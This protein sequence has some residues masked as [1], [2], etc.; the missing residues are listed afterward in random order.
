MPAAAAAKQ[1]GLVGCRVWPGRLFRGCMASQ[2]SNLQLAAASVQVRAQGCEH[3]VGARRV[4]LKQ[5]G[6][7]EWGRV[8]TG[9]EETQQATT[10]WFWLGMICALDT[11]PCDHVVV[12]Q[13][14][15]RDGAGQHTG[16]EGG[17]VEQRAGGNPGRAAGDQGSP[18]AS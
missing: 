15:W 4:F 5:Q 10:A 8:H 12:S 1:H 7:G 2:S 11:L 3:T 18:G 6:W 16:W 14:P 9:F 13:V 17:G